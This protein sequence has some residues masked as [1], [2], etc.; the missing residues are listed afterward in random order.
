MQA[1]REARPPR[2]L[3]FAFAFEAAPSGHPD[4]EIASAAELA[5]GLVQAR[6]RRVEFVERDGQRRAQ[7]DDPS[8]AELEAEAPGEAAI[9]EAVGEAGRIA[10]ADLDPEIA[11]EPTHVPDEGIAGAN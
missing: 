5:Q 3:A 2:A 1:A 10:A 8:S 7:R 6:Q 11:A 4:W 9:D